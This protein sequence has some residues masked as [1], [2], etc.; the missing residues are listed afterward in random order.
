MSVGLSIS[1]ARVRRFARARMQFFK[2]HRDYLRYYS[3][4]RGNVMKLA[5]TR[6]AV[7]TLRAVTLQV[8]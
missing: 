7:V 3:R 4:Y 2:T 8:R 6:H 5:L 1:R